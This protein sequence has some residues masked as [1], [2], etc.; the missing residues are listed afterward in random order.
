MVDRPMKVKDLI[1]ILQ[2]AARP[3]DE[4]YLQ[5]KNG[6]HVAPSLSVRMQHPGS[7]G[8]GHMVLIY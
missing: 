7:N 5:A 8:T 3:D 4:V 6:D 1:E 2:T